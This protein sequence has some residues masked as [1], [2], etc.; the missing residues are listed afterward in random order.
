MSVLKQITVKVFNSKM[1]DVKEIL[2][3]AKLEISVK[4]EGF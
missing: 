1:V 3:I 2:D 4:S